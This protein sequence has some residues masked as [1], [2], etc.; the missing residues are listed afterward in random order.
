M[1]QEFLDNVA[2]S[3]WLTKLDMNKDFYQVTPVKDSLDK[4]AFCSERGKFAFMSM[5]FSLMNVPATFQHCMHM[6]LNQQAEYSATYIDN[7]Q[8]YSFSWEEHSEHI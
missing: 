8:I 1:V 2:C 6:S 5:P 4:T 7:V 3:T